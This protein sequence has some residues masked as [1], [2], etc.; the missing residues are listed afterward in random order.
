MQKQTEVKSEGEPLAAWSGKGLSARPPHQAC[1][2][3]ETRLL[4]PELRTHSFSLSALPSFSLIIY[5]PMGHILMGRL[6]EFHSL[7]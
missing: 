6:N 4:A 7:L 2:R 3:S 1:P 5:R